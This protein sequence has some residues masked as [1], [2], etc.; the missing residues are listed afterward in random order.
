M[1]KQLCK[2]VGRLYRALGGFEPLS[3]KTPTPE[4]RS[5]EIVL[6]AAYRYD[7]SDNVSPDWIKSLLSEL[8]AREMIDKEIVQVYCRDTYERDR[9][10]QT[11]RAIVKVVKPEKLSMYAPE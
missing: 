8:I 6:R 4:R 11:V 7:L 3:L 9:V 1:K 2:W 5:K 10:M